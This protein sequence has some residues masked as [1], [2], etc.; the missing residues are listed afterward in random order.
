MTVKAPHDDNPLFV[1]CGFGIGRVVMHWEQHVEERGVWAEE[2]MHRITNLHKLATNLEEGLAFERIVLGCHSRAIARA[3]SLVAA[4]RSLDHLDAIESRSWVHALREIAGG[5]VEVFG[6]SVGSVVVSLEVTPLHLSARQQRALLLAASEL[7]V[8]A[9]M[10]AFPDRG[11]GVIRVSAMYDEQRRC[12]VLS[13]SDDGVGL[14]PGQSSCPPC[15]GCSI[16][17]ELA[18]IADGEVTWQR[19][20]LLGGTEAVFSFPYLDVM[21]HPQQ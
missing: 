6:R 16:V 5:L 14:S 8:N 21:E 2:A 15:Q 1:L 12:V 17:R 11:S 9:L 4:Y 18:D 3:R 13:V 20:A 19:C 7:V 10:H